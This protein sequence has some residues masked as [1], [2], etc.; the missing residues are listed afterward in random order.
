MIFNINEVERIKNQTDIL[1]LEKYL[2]SIL[3]F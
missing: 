3:G 1:T 2:P